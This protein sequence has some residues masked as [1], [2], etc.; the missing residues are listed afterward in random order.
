MNPVSVTCPTCFS[1]F[2]IP[3]PDPSEVPA[4]VDYDCEICCRPMVIEFLEV[5]G[6]I[7]AEAHGLAD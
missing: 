1:T 2:E 5:D 6:E 3:A 4:A 7:T